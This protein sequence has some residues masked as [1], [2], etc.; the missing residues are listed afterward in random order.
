VVEQR[1]EEFH[2]SRQR[3]QKIK[4]GRASL[5]A[6]RAKYASSNSSTDSAILKIV[7]IPLSV[8]LVGLLV[9]WRGS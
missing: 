2:R 7:F 6:T 5:Y 4:T 3:N 9:F 1:S 8:L